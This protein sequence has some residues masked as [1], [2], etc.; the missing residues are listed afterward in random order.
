M[1]KLSDPQGFF[2]LTYATSE[3]PHEAFDDIDEVEPNST[4]TINQEFS[5][6]DQA[7][8][9]SDGFLTLEL[10]LA[11][12]KT[13]VMRSILKY[14]MRMQI[15]GVYTLSP[16]P[17]VLL[18]VNA[19]TPNYAIHQIIMLLRQR[20]HTKLDIFNLSLTGSYE[21][22]IT[23][24]NV[25][26]SYISRTVI[27]FGNSFN[28]FQKEIK[29]PWELLDMWETAWLLKGGTSLLFA[30]V[31]GGEGVKSLQLWA[32]NATFP[33]Y[34]HPN[35]VASEQP[36]EKEKDAKTIATTL[37][38]AGPD[39]ATTVHPA[40][41]RYPVTLSG[42]SCFSTVESAIDKSAAGVAK[43]LTKEMPLRRFVAFPDRQHPQTPGGKTGAVVVC[44]GVPRTAK[45]VASVGHFGPSPPGTYAI[46]D[47]DMYFIVSSLPFALRASMFWNAAGRIQGGG[48]ITCAALYRGS[49]SFLQLPDGANSDATFVDEKV[50]HILFLLKRPLITSSSCCTTD[51]LEKIVIS[52]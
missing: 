17:S 19:S 25:L 4:V 46:S 37:R 36:G 48:N 22:P 45:M 52:C 28:Y 3:N 10:L 12:P 43:E 14:Q 5:V 42:L 39:T 47:Y 41:H 33:A 24:R 23:K 32:A 7:M 30:N 44:E 16:E 13:G 2:L 31:A 29:S 35:A 40:T 9:F 27:I 51:F 50:R 34:D 21:S 1:T 18:V 11:D 15:S 6:N 8:E 20:L 38:K 49:E 26:S